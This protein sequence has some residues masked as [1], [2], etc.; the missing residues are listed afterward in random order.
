MK[1]V[2]TGT[3]GFVGAE[4]LRQC[5]I[6]PSITSVIVL[7]RR[8]LDPAIADPKLKVVIHEDFTSYPPH[9]LDELKGAEAC[10]W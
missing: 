4:V 10:I 5:L 8:A 2:L 1:V 6:H 9:V 7:S 3:T